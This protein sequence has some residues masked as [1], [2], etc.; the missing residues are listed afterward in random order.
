MG[1]GEAQTIV[2]SYNSEMKP[3]RFAGHSI[4]LAE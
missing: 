4:R 1:N 3:M 2:F